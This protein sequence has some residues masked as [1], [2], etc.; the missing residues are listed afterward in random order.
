MLI[1]WLSEDDVEKYSRVQDSELNELLQEVRC[2]EGYLV[3]E[4]KYAEKR[5]LRKSRYVELYTVYFNVGIKPELNEYQ[6]LHLPSDSN[7]NGS[8]KVSKAVAAAFLL[9]LLNGYA[10]QPSSAAAGSNADV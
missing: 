6:L 4:T 1:T 3:Q 10:C 2:Q 8:Y 5:W 7:K 9:G